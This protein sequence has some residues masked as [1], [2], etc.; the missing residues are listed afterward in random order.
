MNDIYV[1]EAIDVIPPISEEELETALDA[2]R[3]AKVTW[4]DPRIG[5]GYFAQ[6]AKGTIGL[7]MFPRLDDAQGLIHEGVTIEANP[8]AEDHH[9]SGLEEELQQILEDFGTAPDGSARRFD[10]GIYIENGE[11]VYKMVI[12]DGRPLRS[13]VR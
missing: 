11:E 7:A 9:D 3:Y 4:E 12:T 2:G 6:V 5:D 10:R 13:R 1:F 8:V